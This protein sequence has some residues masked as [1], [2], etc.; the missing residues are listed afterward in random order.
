M[1]IA[2]NDTIVPGRD[3][4]AAARFFAQLFWARPFSASCQA[5][6]RYLSRRRTHVHT[7]SKRQQDMRTKGAT[8]HILQVGSRI[9]VIYA[10]P[11]VQCCR[12]L[13]AV[14][15]GLGRAPSSNDLRKDRLEY[16]P[17]YA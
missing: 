17:N 14:C 7:S 6:A 12:W 1:T 8:A 4:E 5:A 3:K 10:E 13:L 2:L 15:S 9:T 16:S 11:W